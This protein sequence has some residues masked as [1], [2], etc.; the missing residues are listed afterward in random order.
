MNGFDFV[1]MFGIGTNFGV[2][3]EDARP[4]GWG[5]WVGDSQ[6]LPTN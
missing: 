6:L 1:L 4:G 2:G 5:S 3:V